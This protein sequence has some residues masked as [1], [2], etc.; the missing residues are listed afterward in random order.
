MTQTQQLFLQAAKAALRGKH[1]D[2][3]QIEAEQ[4]QELMELAQNQ[5]MVPLL[6]EAVYTSAAFRMLPEETKWQARKL[7]RQQVFAQTQKDRI[8]YGLLEG[9]EK[10]K[11]PVLVLKGAACRSLYRLPE[12]RPSSDE[13]LL[14]QPEHFEQATQILLKRGFR[15]EAEEMPAEAY[16]VSFVSPEGMHIELH[17]HPLD[18]SLSVLEG[19][20][21][22]FAGV[23]ADKYAIQI[24]G[25]Q[26]PSMPPHEH[27]LY[28]L[29]HAFKHLIYRG[30][31]LRQM[32]DI[33]LWG[34]RY[35]ADID[36]KRL[37]EQCASLRA[38]DF[39]Q[40]I[41]TVGRTHLGVELPVECGDRSEQAGILLEDVFSGGVYGGESLS[42]KHSAN[43][44][45][46][47]VEA[48]QKGKK[49][50]VLASVFPA[51]KNLEGRYPWLSKHPGLLPLAWGKRLADYA[52]QPKNEDNDPLDSMRIGRERVELLRK[53]N[54][55]N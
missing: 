14:V 28:L 41:F 18:P 50:S 43:I 38:W 19:A 51:R 4:W 17:R 26:I 21:G 42:R 27:M 40:A 49:P 35:A 12:T 52:A 11:L 33:L 7:A 45:L 44:T 10:A 31:G 5:H 54:V 16:E 32:C 13:D 47:A 2:W 34:E 1:V 36:W 24:R 22:C 20:N 8:L 53:L 6:V 3:P 15:C 39:A 29:L 46:N 9:M 30:F 23:F 25:G 55:I 48:E 37:E